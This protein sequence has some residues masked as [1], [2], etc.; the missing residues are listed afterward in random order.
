[1]S[2]LNLWET[3]EDLAENYLTYK[4]IHEELAKVFGDVVGRPFGTMWSTSFG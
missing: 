3:T 1:M 2:N 4:H